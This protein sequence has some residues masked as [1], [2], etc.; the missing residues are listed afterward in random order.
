M[1]FGNQTLM[2]LSA[3]FCD[4]C[5][6]HLTSGCVG[7]NSQQREADKHKVVPDTPTKTKPEL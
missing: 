3:E 5:C 2:A 6:R 1:L 7:Y 4:I